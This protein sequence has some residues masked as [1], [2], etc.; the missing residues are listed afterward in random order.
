MAVMIPLKRT[1]GGGEAALQRTISLAL[2][3]CED[4]EQKE[5]EMAK[6]TGQGF[7][8][9]EVRGR[10]QVKNPKTGEW[11]KRDSETGRFIDG[12]KNGQ[13]FKGVR[14]EGE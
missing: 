1:Q 8:R 6:N 5:P 4:R 13:P 12:K 14:K 11:T 3:R 2:K 7:R 10:S 9:G